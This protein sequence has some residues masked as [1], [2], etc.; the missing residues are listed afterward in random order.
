MA[1]PHSFDYYGFVIDFEIRKCEISTAL[2]SEWLLVEVRGV[3][4]MAEG[5]E[6]NNLK[7]K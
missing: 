3:P 7:S 2:T 4:V 5:E 1:V 6:M